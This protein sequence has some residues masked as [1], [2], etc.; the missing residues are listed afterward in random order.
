MKERVPAKDEV[1]RLAVYG[2]LAP[3]RKN[4]W[5]LEG[6]KGTW[7]AGTVRGHLHQEGWGAT[8]GYPALVHDESGPEVEV[9]VL[10][11]DEL[12]AQ[13][14]RIDDFEGPGYQ[15]S[16]VPVLL[17]SGQK[18]LCHIYELNRQR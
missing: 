15:R 9:Q 13:W 8:E 5:V 14:K 4:H 16:V 1:T 7:S 10:E 12:R 6:L 3:G 17:S 18:V 2:T 11:S